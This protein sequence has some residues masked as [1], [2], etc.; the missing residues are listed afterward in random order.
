MKEGEPIKSAREL[1][2][3]AQ[4]QLV[5]HDRLIWESGYS[6]G[7]FHSM[8]ERKRRQILNW[9]EGSKC[10]SMATLNPVLDK[11][12]VPINSVM[13]LCGESG[14]AIDTEKNG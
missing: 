5:L 9:E 7:R 14:E 12:D 11:K 1:I 13:G 3:R 10:A 8:E 4:I 2:E 6:E